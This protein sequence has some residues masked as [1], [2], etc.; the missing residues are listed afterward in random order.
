M[1]DKG[2][3][4]EEYSTHHFNVGDFFVARLTE[5]PRAILTHGEHALRRK[6]S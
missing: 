2:G 1:R 5:V 4:A 6:E 3:D